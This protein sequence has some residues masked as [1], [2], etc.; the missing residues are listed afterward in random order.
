MEG[1][2]IATVSNG[3]LIEQADYEIKRVLENIMD[4]NTDPTKKRKV[5]IT[6]EF[7][8]TEDR[9][10]TSVVFVTKSVLA[11]TLPIG[12][13]IVFEKDRAGNIIAEELTKGALKG[14]VAIDYETG[15]IKEPQIPNRVVN[16]K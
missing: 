2:N 5:T 15:E 10:I 9:D 11:P 1:F 12:S 8:G 7:K 4:P 14:Q 6:L 16:L 13:R 3:A